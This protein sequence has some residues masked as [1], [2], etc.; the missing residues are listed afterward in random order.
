MRG[1][2]DFS[3]RFRSSSSLLHTLMPLKA[4]QIERQKVRPLPVGTAAR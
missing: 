2:T 4:K 1:I 3:T